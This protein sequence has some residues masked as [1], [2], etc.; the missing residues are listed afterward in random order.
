[1]RKNLDWFRDLLR[2]ADPK[3]T[4]G[5]SSR[6]GDY[7]I[8]IPSR[9]ESL[10]SDNEDEDTIWTVYVHRFSKSD[11]DTVADKIETILSGADMVGFDY[12]L[13]YD[14]ETKYFN[15][16]FTCYVPAE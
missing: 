8:W 11:H 5:Y 15:H 9:P 14:P 4:R 13:D 3:L 6:Q 10:M 2:K 7:T 16:I 1:M 12:E